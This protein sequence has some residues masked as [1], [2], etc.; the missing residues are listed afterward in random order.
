MREI[1]TVQHSLTTAEADFTGRLRVSALVNLLIQAARQSATRLGVGLEDLQKDHLFW[2]LNR[3]HL[4]IDTL[5]HW[6]DEL[7]I[8][9]WPRKVQG[10]SYYR[11]FE[12]DDNR[13]QTTIR[14]TSVWLAIHQ[15]RKRPV[16]V[17]DFNRLNHK[18]AGPE[19][20]PKPP[21][22]TQGAINRKMIKPGYFDFD[23]NGHVTTTRYIDWSMDQLTLPF[24]QRHTPV[25]FTVHFMREI[26][27][28]DEVSLAYQ[29]HE[30]EWLFEGFKGDQPAYRMAVTFNT[31]EE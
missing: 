16:V 29:S 28:G 24:H 14:G 20:V 18:R 19:E 13:G 8:R 15:V 12:V 30:G 23:L 22:I 11:D 17:K 10:V 5:P 27:P 1:I 6:P 3:L 7:V 25:Q 9:T 4:D 21:G 2:A 31:M 26:L